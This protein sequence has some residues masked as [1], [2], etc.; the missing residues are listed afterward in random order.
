VGEE[1]H[2]LF[3][4]GLVPSATLVLVPIAGATSAYASN[5]SGYIGSAYGAASW[6]AG[7]VYGMLD[8]LWSYVPSFG[9]GSGPYIGGTGDQQERSNAEGAR[10]AGSDSA[11]PGGATNIGKVRGLADQRKDDKVTTFYN[12]N[13]SAFEGRK[14]DEDEK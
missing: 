9:G 10:M 1:H 7:S 6:A 2:S 8:T 12:G 14:E 11:A 13:S 3:D 4:L 5:N